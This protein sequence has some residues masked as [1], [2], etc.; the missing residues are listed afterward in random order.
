MTAPTLY[1]Y[2]R[3]ATD[4][5]KANPRCGLFLDMGLGKAL[6]NESLI[7]TP[8]GNRRVKDIRVGDELYDRRGKPTRVLAVYPHTDKTAY[9]VTLRSGRT[10]V[11]CDEHL[12]P[13]IDASGNI[14]HRPLREM[15]DD[16]LLPHSVH[17]ALQKPEPRYHLPMND[18]V[19][20]PSVHPTLDPYA[21]GVWLM[22]HRSRQS[23]T[24]SFT[25]NLQDEDVA[26]KT[27][28]EQRAK[29]SDRPHE[30][31]FQYR[32]TNA[33]GAARWRTVL[34]QLDLFGK[35]SRV[36]HIPDMYLDASVTERRALLDAIVD[37]IGTIDYAMVGTLTQSPHYRIPVPAETELARDIQRLAFSLGIYAVLDERGGSSVRLYTTKTLGILQ[38]YAHLYDGLVDVASDPILDI[39]PVENRD[40]TC[41]TVDND[42]KLF[43]IDDYIVTHNTLITLTGLVELA[44]EGRL[45]GHILVVAPKRIAVNTWPDEIEKWEHVRGA[46]YVNFAGITKKKR[47]ALFDD[48]ATSPPTIYIINR[49]L[50]PQLVDRFPG[51]QWQFPN[52]IID[53]AQSFKGYSSKGFKAL[54]S[55]APFTR[56]IVELTGTPAPN[57]LLDI[58]SLIYLI[59]GGRRLGPNITAFRTT[60]FDPGRQ[61]N[62][63]PYEW[64]LKH[65]HDAIIHDRIKDVAI[66]MMKEDHLSMPD[67]VHNVIEL[68]MTKAERK[69][70]QQL[71]TDKVLPLAN[72]GEIGSDNAAALFGALF[73]LANGA[74]YEDETRQDVIELHQHKLNALQDIIDGANG[75]PVLV[76]YWFKHDLRRM[77]AHIPEAVEFT[78]KPE[79]LR[80]WNDKKIPVLLAHPASA[81]HGLNFQHGG[82]ILVFFCVPTS[83]E[84]YKQ[85]I[86]RLHRNGQTQTVIVHYLKMRGTIENQIVNTLGEKDFAQQALIDAVKAHL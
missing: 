86:A 72:G 29:L 79:Q 17:H 19:E 75:Q 7:P 30:R 73:Q 14:T 2:Q 63:Y 64:T 32:W 53:E 58:W 5:M 9:R 15:C 70:Y 10:F 20:R 27:L 42:E 21:F 22:R 56:R 47:D 85:S 38:R 45:V 57:N 16:Y 43:L 65:G 18:A 1:P 66:S 51:D 40:M 13:Y 74:I 4:F 41:F 54:K 8:R 59:D 61:I 24:L 84:L 55:I 31:G 77:L 69:I 12:V 81:G 67:V 60:H 25:R 36:T 68:D 52:I 76:F 50:I 33:H 78:G 6:D 28:F 37:S 48:V 71:K 23:V 39:T 80:D 82:H 35:D 46:R 62:G 3:V 11:A 34:R 49:E 26:L 44:N 83:L